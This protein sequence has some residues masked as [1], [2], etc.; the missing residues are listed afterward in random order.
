MGYTHTRPNECFAGVVSDPIPVSVDEKGLLRA[1][2][3][4]VKPGSEI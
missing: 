1:E 4:L 2:V 3:E